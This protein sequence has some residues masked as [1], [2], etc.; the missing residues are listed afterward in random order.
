[1]SP[2]SSVVPV[3]YAAQL[4]IGLNPELFSGVMVLQYHVFETA[5]HL[6]NPVVHWRLTGFDHGQP[7]VS[8]ETSWTCLKINFGA[9]WQ[10]PADSWPPWCMAGQD[11]PDSEAY[12]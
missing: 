3:P 5:V 2:E 12:P 9:I 8:F 10:S 4:P 6:I 7:I 11:T 1:V